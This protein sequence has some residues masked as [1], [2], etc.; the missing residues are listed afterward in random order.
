MAFQILFGADEHTAKDGPYTRLMSTRKWIY[1][2]SALA[3][4]LISGLYDEAAAKALLKVVALPTWL[5][6]PAVAFGLLYLLAQY[7]LLLGQLWVS[8]D[9][10]MGE[11]LAFRRADELN[12][13][14]QR[15]KEASEAVEK[16][17]AKIFQTREERLVSLE[18]AIISTAKLRDQAHEEALVLVSDSSLNA[19]GRLAAV[20]ERMKNLDDE[21]VRLADEKFKARR[22][23][24]EAV[25]LPPD[26]DLADAKALLAQLSAQ[27]P[28]DRKGYRS[29]EMMIDGLR[30]GP[31]MVLG[32]AAA[33]KLGLNIV[34][35]GL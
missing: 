7:A 9:I 5:I 23:N 8:Y 21:M 6:A 26:E 28:A 27:D 2:S 35:V 19:P 29:S 22:E 3:I 32:F 14:K 12:A 33:I 15:V 4:V 18:Q 16:K 10:V 1:V 24:S 11:R 34:Q 30:L 25:R 17:A 31:P 20:N 13:A